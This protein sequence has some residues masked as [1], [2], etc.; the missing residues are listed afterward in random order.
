[1]VPYHVLLSN[2]ALDV[3]VGVSLLEGFGEGGVLCVAV[4]GHHSLAALPQP[5]QG[6]T[7]CL[8]GGN[9]RR[10]VQSN[11]GVNKY[12]KISNSIS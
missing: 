11:L 6:N 2:K 1:M 8:P 12:V 7:V 5:G 4:E 10:G 3:A 9:L